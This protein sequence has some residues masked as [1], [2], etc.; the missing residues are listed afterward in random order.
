MQAEG[1]FRREARR[2]L[3]RLDTPGAYLRAV[4]KGEFGLFAPRN[5][6]RKPVATVPEPVVR[7]FLS[8]GLIEAGTMPP[9]AAPPAA[10]YVLSSAG[11]SFLRR[12]A[13]RSDNP[14]A[15]QHRLM[16]PKA[17][18]PDGR[19]MREVAVNDG[20][21][22]IGWLRSRKGPGGRPLLSEAACD[23]AD[24][25]REDFT[26]A[27]LTPRVTA[28]WSLAPG[29]APKR[30]SGD[31]ALVITEAALAARQRVRRALEAVGPGLSD[32]LLQVCCH[33]KGLEEAER[34]LGWPRRSG[35]LVLSMALERLAVHYGM[36]KDRNGAG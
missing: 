18:A 28:D 13:A 8:R 33:L 1:E 27:R 26:L 31:A 2:L 34:D 22:P 32:A 4:N 25:L 7:G 23:A 15:E 10:V 5:R 16:S 14:H 30:R 19:A 20:E 12:L 9:D 11:A 17:F 36:G 24:R 35:K 29:T 3:P 21:S 6:Y